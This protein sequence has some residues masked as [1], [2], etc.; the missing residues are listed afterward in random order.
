MSQSDNSR[1]HAQECMRFEAD[2]M[3]LAEDVRS[4]ALQ[5]HFDRMA[6]VRFAMAVGG[7]SSTTI[8]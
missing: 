1:K 4:A 2:C 6:N 7:A 5:A 8:N 3:Q